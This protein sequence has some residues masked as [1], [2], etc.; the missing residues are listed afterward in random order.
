MRNNSFILMCRIRKE[1][2]NIKIFKLEYFNAQY[3]MIFC[4][5]LCTHRLQGPGFDTR[6]G[7]FTNFFIL[8]R[9]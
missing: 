1:F 5:D 3:P 7:Q 6:P 8:S 2:V 4:D 9:L